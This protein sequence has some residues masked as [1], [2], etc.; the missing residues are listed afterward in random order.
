MKVTHIGFTIIEVL[1]VLTIFITLLGIGYVSVVGIERRAPI[2]ATENTIIADL[3]GQQTKAMT[4]NARTGSSPDSYGVHFEQN[5]YT[6]FK[7]V[8]YNASD[9]TNTVT[10]LPTN[11]TLSWTL[12]NASLIF[13]KGSGDVSG[14]SAIGNTF[15]I[16][17]TLTGEYKT[18]T[19]NR[20]GAVTDI[21]Q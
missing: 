20:Y 2:T 14:Y 5:S 12:P 9:P 1:V 8:A 13:T 3:R 16:T 10:E 19:I 17:Q 15:T 7:G 6:L 21:Q 18:I 4:G 11:V